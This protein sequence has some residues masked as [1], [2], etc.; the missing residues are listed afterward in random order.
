M[1]RLRSVVVVLILAGSTVVGWGGQRRVLGQLIFNEASAVSSDQFMDGNDSK[2]YEGFDFGIVPYSGNSAFGG[3]PFPPDIDLVTPD[4][5]QSLPNGWSGTT[6]WARLLGN[7]GDW[8][9]LVV[10][11]DHTDLRGYT[12]FWAYDSDDDDSALPIL[13][14][15]GNNPDERGFIRFSSDVSFADLR[16]GTIITLS[17][18][19]TLDEVSDPY[20]LGPADPLLAAD[21][22]YDY[23]LSTDTSFDPYTNHDWN[24]HYY[25]DESQ[26][27]LGNATQYFEAYSDIKVT[28]D[29]WQIMVF[30]ASNGTIANESEDPSLTSLLQFSDLSTGLIQGPIG[31]AVAGWGTAVP[32][33]GG[34]V[35]SREVMTLRADPTSGVGPEAF[36]DTDFSTFG[37]P[38]LYNANTED[39]LDGVQDFSALRN[40]VLENTFRWSPAVG[41]SDVNVASNWQ[42]A[43]TQA[44]ATAGPTLAWTSQFLNVSSGNA[45]AEVS[46]RTQVGFATIAANNGGTMTVHVQAGGSLTSSAGVLGD[47]NQNG[48]VDAA[49]YTIWK[50]GFG[51]SVTP[52]DGADGNGNGTIDAADYTVWKDN[53]GSQG[54]GTG[55][56][57]DAR[58]LVL[59][60]GELRVDG[61]VAYPTVEVFGGGTVGGNGSVRGDLVNSGGTVA[62]G[63][64]A[65]VLSISGDYVQHAGSVL[66]IDVNG[67]AA[68]QHDHLSI[69]GDARLDGDLQIVLGYTPQVGD[70]IEVLTASALSGNMSLV[71]DRSGFS[72]IA[73]SGKLVLSYTGGVGAVPEPSTAL[74][75]CVACAVLAR[76]RRP[77]RA[78]E[79]C[80]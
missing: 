41:T 40:P 55:G 32:G 11:E 22:N 68:G 1:I 17:E 72:L 2:P 54:G 24:V 4:I 74:L 26:L 15:A 23:D 69:S 6:G 64:G 36:E 45:L 7:G 63:T 46:Q 10:T 79:R 34:S 67:T 75:V 33:G 43:A 16:A 77:N 39:T 50:D 80:C 76:F 19:A 5:Q 73:E 56:A 3:N 47:Y 27:D 62:P 60:G 42:V 25:V 51:S 8:I 61:A 29:T 12:L 14:R 48:T 44:T 78:G 20:P 37:T 30:D 70:R 59:A 71:G 13:E 58:L 38:N 53:F 35:N 28:S 31:E 21:T 52:G 49:D 57:E 18:D 65:G 9:E 66:T